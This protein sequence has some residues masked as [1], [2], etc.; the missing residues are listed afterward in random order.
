MYNDGA[1]RE[2]DLP[3]SH[4]TAGRP[5]YK[6]QYSWLSVQVVPSYFRDLNCPPFTTDSPPASS[7]L[8]SLLRSTFLMTF[9]RIP[10]ACSSDK[11][12]SLGLKGRLYQLIP[13]L[14]SQ[15]LCFYIPFN[16]LAIFVI[17]LFPFSFTFLSLSLARPHWFS[18]NNISHFCLLFSVPTAIFSYWQD[19]S[20]LFNDFLLAY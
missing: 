9:E 18:F 10:P 17:S 4:L 1:Q 7:V 5:R 6:T 19:G 12:N 3:R 15:L 16:N 13:S 11:S 2:G 8:P 20:S 14:F